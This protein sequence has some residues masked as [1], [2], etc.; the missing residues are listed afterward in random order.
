MSVRVDAV[1]LGRGGIVVITATKL[2]VPVSGEVCHT[3]Q[4]AA[5]EA[6]QPLIYWCSTFYLLPL[7]NAKQG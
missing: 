4:E 3:T 7:F 1:T 5:E 2:S 6:S